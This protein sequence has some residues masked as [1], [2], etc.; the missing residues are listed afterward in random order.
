MCGFV[1]NANKFTHHCIM[2]S[3]LGHKDSV[4][5]TGF[6]YDGKYVA[7]GD[8]SGLVQVWKVASGECIWTYECTDLEVRKKRTHLTKSCNF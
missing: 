4:T 8:M 5:S 3:I 1:H 2:V 6:S 7:T